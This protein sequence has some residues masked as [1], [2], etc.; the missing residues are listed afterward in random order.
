ML[1]M[2]LDGELVIAESRDVLPAADRRGSALNWVQQCPH[3]GLKRCYDVSGAASDSLHLKAPRIAAQASCR[4]VDRWPRVVVFARS[5]VLAVDR[6][7]IPVQPGAYN[8]WTRPGVAAHC[9]SEGR[10]VSAVIGSTM[11]NPFG[12]YITA[13][14]ML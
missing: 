4:V 10:V 13:A 14:G 5:G 11:V 1:A 12:R 7:L 6:V 3:S 8:I 9:R 2:H